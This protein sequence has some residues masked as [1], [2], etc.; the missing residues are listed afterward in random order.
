VITITLQSGKSIEIP[1]QESA[2]DSY[3]PPFKEEK[4]K[5]PIAYMPKPPYPQR[6]KAENKN[7]DPKKESK[8]EKDATN[9]SIKSQL[10][11]QVPYLHTIMGSNNKS[12]MITKDVYNKFIEPP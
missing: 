8:E 6:L 11:Q 10:V 3:S 1:N 12:Y 4:K 9:D 5:E 2:E 7:K